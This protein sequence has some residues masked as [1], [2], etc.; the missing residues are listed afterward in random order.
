M[1]GYKRGEMGWYHPDSLTAGSVR[2]LLRVRRASDGRGRP[3]NPYTACAVLRPRADRQP[4]LPLRDGALL[5]ADRGAQPVFRIRRFR[6]CGPAG[7]IVYRRARRRL[8]PGRRG[9]NG[10]IPEGVTAGAFGAHVVRKNKRLPAAG[11][12]HRGRKPFI[13]FCN[14]PGY[15]PSAST[16]AS[17]FSVSLPVANSSVAPLR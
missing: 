2:V 3:G 17:S 6:G 16:S 14:M 5:G 9:E 4:L 7:R 11:S 10:R 15:T 1:R 13:C 12:A 8:Y